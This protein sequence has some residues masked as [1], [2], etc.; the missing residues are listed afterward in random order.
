M[1]RAGNAYGYAYLLPNGHLLASSAPYGAVEN[2][3]EGCTIWL[4]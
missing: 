4:N 2:D 1:D 3:R